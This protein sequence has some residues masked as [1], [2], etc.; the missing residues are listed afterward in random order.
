MDKST[1]TSKMHTGVTKNG[2]DDC[3]EVL[4][5]TELEN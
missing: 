3:E 4:T 2:R 5:F 1:T